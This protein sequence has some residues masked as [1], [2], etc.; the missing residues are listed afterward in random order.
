MQSHPTAIGLFGKPF[1][2]FD[3]LDIVFGKNK[4]SDNAAEDTVDM[5]APIE[6]EQFAST[7]GGGLG[8]N[9]DDDE[10]YFVSQILET[11]TTNTTT[12]WSNPTNQSQRDST[13]YRTEKRGG[14]KVKHNDD[15]SYSLLTS[16]NKLGEFYA[17]GVENMKQL[18][19][20]FMHEKVTA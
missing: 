15:G 16:V 18:S 4:A 8:I 1:P 11:Q 12:P 17:S 10:D 20:C 6:K 3:S 14:K 19:S 2:H 5:P 13:N 7:H 9:L